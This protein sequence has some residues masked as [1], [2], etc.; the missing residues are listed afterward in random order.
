MNRHPPFGEL[1]G[2]QSLAF[3]GDTHAQGKSKSCCRP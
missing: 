1:A 3:L 2:E